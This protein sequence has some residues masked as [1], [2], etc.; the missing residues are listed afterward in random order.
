MFSET[1]RLF[2]GL[3]HFQEKKGTITIFDRV[4]TPMIVTREPKENG[5]LFG[6]LGVEILCPQE[7]KW[8][9]VS[10][11]GYWDGEKRKFGLYDENWKE[12]SSFIYR[13]DYPPPKNIERE[14]Y[15]ASIKIWEKEYRF[16]LRQR[17]CCLLDDSVLVVRDEQFRKV[18]HNSYEKA[19]PY[20]KVHVS[21]EQSFL[22]MSILIPLGF[23]LQNKY[24]FDRT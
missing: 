14:I 13:E 4:G 20:G 24:K 3:Y 15:V 17:R 10:Q 22:L 19:R 1:T 6:A 5:F 7:V 2:K 11:R 21:Q 12:V 8:R 16:S 23:R 9:Y 18:F